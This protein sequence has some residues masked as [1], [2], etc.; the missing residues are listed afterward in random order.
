MFAS[1]TDWPTFVVSL[2]ALSVSLVALVLSWK[3]LSEARTANGGWGMNLRVKPITREDLLAEDAARIDA[4]VAGLEFD[5]VPFQVTF[6]VIGPAIYYQVIPYSW[7]KAGHSDRAESA[8]P[9]PRLSCEDGP[10]DTVSMVQK[11]LVDEIR[12]GVAWLQPSGTGM[13]P[14]AVRFDLD[15]E[16][17]EWVWRNPVVAKLPFVAAGSWKRRKRPK[18]SVGPLTQPWEL[19]RAG[20]RGQCFKREAKPNQNRG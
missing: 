8:P 15:G 20:K 2:T 19:K 14:G 9:I 18:S 6:E 17:E 1:T 11:E 3:Q 5:C 10:V 12:F 4:A 7:G 13:L 16:I